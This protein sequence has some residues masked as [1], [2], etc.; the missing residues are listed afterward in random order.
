V[1]S[2]VKIAAEG[3]HTTGFDEASMSK[4]RVALNDLVEKAWVELDDHIM[5]CKEYKEMSGGTFDQV[6][7]HFCYVSIFLRACLR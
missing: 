1:S 4:A 2:L 5:E 7:G 6:A 3:G